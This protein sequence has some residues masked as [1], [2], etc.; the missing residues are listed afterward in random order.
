MGPVKVVLIGLFVVCAWAPTAQAVSCAECE[1]DYWD[2]L[3]A[4]DRKY[5]GCIADAEYYHKTVVKGAWSACSGAGTGPADPVVAGGN[6][7]ACIYYIYVSHQYDAKL[8][9]CRTTKGRCE[10]RACDRQYECVHDCDPF[11]EDSSI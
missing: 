6:L 4:C 3:N 7:V 9:V 11:P 5:D 1:E 2:D 10:S 8:R